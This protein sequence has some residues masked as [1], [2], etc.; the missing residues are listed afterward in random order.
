MLGTFRHF[1]E[2]MVS[3][4]VAIGVT[5]G[6]KMVAYQLKVKRFFPHDLG[7][8]SVVAQRHIVKSP[9]RVCRQVNRIEF[10]MCQCM[11]QSCAALDGGN[12]TIF[13]CGM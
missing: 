9:K 13:D 3:R 1:P 4:E 8:V 7:P 5:K 11:Q 2:R 12:G 10:D 6:R